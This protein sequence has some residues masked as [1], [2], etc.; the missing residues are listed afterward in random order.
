MMMVIMMMMM[1]MMK[2]GGGG[3]DDVFLVYSYS[4]VSSSADDHTH[5][6]VFRVNKEISHNI[7]SKNIVSSVLTS[8]QQFL[9]SWA[10]VHPQK[11]ITE[12]D[13]GCLPIPFYLILVT[14]AV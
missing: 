8:Q 4:A 10:V 5:G 7:S 9:G 6:S 11:T 2:G 3:E 13:N 14:S 1:M 12:P